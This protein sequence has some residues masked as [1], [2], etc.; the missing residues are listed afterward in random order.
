MSTPNQFFSVIKNIQR[1]VVS[2]PGS[3]AQTLTLSPVALSAKS[4]VK[5]TSTP[6][7]GTFTYA[8]NTSGDN[9]TSVSVSTVSYSGTLQ[10]EVTEF[11]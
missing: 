1:L 9:I 4:Q 8:V 7:T 2:S 10:V 11:Y 3:V 6:S 5:V